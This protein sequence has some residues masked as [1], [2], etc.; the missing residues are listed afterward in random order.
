M[1]TTTSTDRA[2]AATGAGDAGGARTDTGVGALV[3]SMPAGA[4]LA[5]VLD[6]VDFSTLSNDELT[7]VLVAQDRQ[8]SHETGRKVELVAQIG[9]RLEVPEKECHD[10]PWEM[11]EFEIQLGLVVT[12]TSA[13]RWCTLAYFAWVTAPAVGQAL[14]AGLLDEARARVFQL[15]TDP[16]S[17]EHTRAVVEKLLPEAMQLTTAQLRKRIAEMAIALDPA[18][19]KRRYERAVRRRRVVGYSN[20][21][22]CQRICVTKNG[23]VEL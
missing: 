20:S 11:G 8:V 12:A 14:T 10:W 22:G 4:R 21:G 15:W 5:A 7:Q 2:G 17:Q 18:W 19:V 23:D 9:R 16:L 13:S 6:S 3:E 1:T